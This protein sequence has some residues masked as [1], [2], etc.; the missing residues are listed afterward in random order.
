MPRSKKPAVSK[1]KRADLEMPVARV[2]RMLKRGCY[3]KRLS[4]AT[5]VYLAA[6]LEYLVG[7]VLDLA[8]DV[9]KNE[10]RKRIVP[11]NIFKGIQEDDGLVELF[12]NIVISE[13]GFNENVHESLLMKKK[14]SRSQRSQSQSGKKSQGRGRSKSKSK[15][16]RGR[17]KSKGKGRGKSQRASQAV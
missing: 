16:K 3:Y 15:S 17:S 13:G 10:G 8:G 6:V 4:D 1:S 7:E 5:P 9:C 14:R 12:S 2:G 11:T